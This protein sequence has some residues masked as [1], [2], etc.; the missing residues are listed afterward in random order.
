MKPACVHCHDRPVNRGR[1]L[2]W[3]CF[4]VPEVRALYG[5]IGPRGQRGVGNGCIR[6][7][8]DLV[9]TPF[10]PGSPGKVAVMERRAAQGLAIFHPLDGRRKKA[11]RR[12]RGRHHR[13]QAAT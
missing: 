13:R 6:P 12:D 4:K 3:A 2:C 1:G 5:P 8:L 11:S 7:P 9:P 10:P